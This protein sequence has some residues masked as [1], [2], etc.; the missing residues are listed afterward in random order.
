MTDGADRIPAGTEVVDA[1]GERLGTI[2]AATAAYV[3]VEQGLFFSTD[4]YIPR[5]AIA[6]V[7]D[8][9]LRL[10]VT[11]AGALARGWEVRPGEAETATAPTE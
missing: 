1:D 3:V 2:V 11:K 5:E 6:A 7:D 10:A 8:G 9:T 4:Y